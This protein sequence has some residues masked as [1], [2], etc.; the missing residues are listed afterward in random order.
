MQ[1]LQLE[2]RAVV[3]EDACSYRRPSERLPVG[4]ELIFVA[5]V[6]AMCWGSMDNVYD[7]FVP[8]NVA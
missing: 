1:Y 5:Y 7:D 4:C 6:V 2:L 8:R 3:M